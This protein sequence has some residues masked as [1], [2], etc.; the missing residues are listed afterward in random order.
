VKSYRGLE[1]WQKSYALAVAAY[2]HT[3]AFPRREVFGLTSQIRRAAVSVPTNIAEGYC[4]PGR[5]DYLRFLGIAQGSAGELS[6]LLSLARDIGYL[7]ACCSQE[8]ESLLSDVGQ[9]LTRLT[10][11][12]RLPGRA[13]AP[14]PM[15]GAAPIPETRDPKPEQEGQSIP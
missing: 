13:S 12:L 4:R 7:D 11:S 5:A 2:R 1:V 9:M 6:T 14:G 3:E 8:L 10:Q 15:D